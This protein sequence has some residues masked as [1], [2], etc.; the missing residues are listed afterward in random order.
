[1]PGAFAVGTTGSDICTEFGVY[2][3]AELATVSCQN[4]LHKPSDAS[5]LVTAWHQTNTLGYNA[6]CGQCLHVQN[7]EGLGDVY[8]T[9]I[10]LKGASGL[11]LNQGPATSFAN[12]IQRGHVNC[13][14]TVVPPSMCSV[15]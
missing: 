13:R 10:D 14:W 4:E 15:H 1:M 11:D 9:V 6:Q 12:L 3:T 7:L 2:G 5:T 8:V